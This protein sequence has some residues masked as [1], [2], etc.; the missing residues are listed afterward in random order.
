MHLLIIGGSDAGISAGL[1]AR[2]LHPDTDVTM[3]VA[4]DYPN[5]SVCGIPYHVSGDVP[6]WHELA[7]RTQ[8][9]L[10]SAG[11]DLRLRTRATHIDPMAHAVT[12]RTPTGADGTIGYDR[13]VVATGAEPSRAGIDGLGEASP[14]GPADGVHVLHSIDD[15]HAVQ[16]DLDRR[17]PTSAVII[18]AGYIG[19]EM[20]EALT[21][22]GID[23]TMVQRG[24]EVLPTLDPDMG[25]L[26]HDEL[27]HHGVTVITGTTAHQVQRS[28]SHLIVAGTGPAGALRIETGLVLAVVGVRPNVRLLTEAG[29]R[30]GSAG[31]V[32]V[33]DHMR[34]GL[35]DIYAAGDGVTTHH[36]LLGPTWLP[37]GTTAHKQ[38]R[39]AGE[40]AT[41]GDVSFAGILGT[42]AVKVFDL[43]AARTGLR[44]S[45][46]RRAGFSPLSVTATPDDHKAYYPGSHPVTIRLTGDLGTDR[47]LGAQLVGAFGAEIAKRVD[48]LATAIHTELTIPQ[49]CDLDLTY[50]PPLA[51]PW[52]AIQSTAQLWAPWTVPKP[53]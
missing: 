12:L 53:A 2:Q 11:L 26:V 16:R 13:L 15:M 5:F 46:A 28:S 51:A 17:R 24:D 9:Q 23:V 29:A 10:E 7:H 19:L 43:V 31:A 20:A 4:D 48:V 38:G 35:P 1:R 44:E 21:R 37:L 40:N 18:G 47:V 22:R 25:R 6:D 42:Q 34:T 8:A 33:D 45:E 3:L 30:L 36:R 27:A 14:L 39:I 49:L 41:G 50:T 52:D 32:S